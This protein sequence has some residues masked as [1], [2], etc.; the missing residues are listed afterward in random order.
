MLAKLSYFS[1]TTKD[2]GSLKY[3]VYSNI[4][5][6]AE[7]GVSGSKNLPLRIIFVILNVKIS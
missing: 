7:K 1:R 4:L 5:T 3:T 6:R 2:V